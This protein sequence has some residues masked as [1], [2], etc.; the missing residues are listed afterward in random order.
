MVWWRS[1]GQSGD[2]RRARHDRVF[3]RPL[4][5]SRLL[6]TVPADSR[7][8]KGEVEMQNRVS[9]AEF[10]RSAK[11]RQ[12]QFRDT[13]R[14]ISDRGRSP[15]DGMGLR[16][17]HLLARG[18]EIENLFPGIRGEGGAID[19]FSQRKIQ[20][21]KN[22]RGVDDGSVDIPTRNMASSQVAC[23]NFLLP[24][25]SIPGALASALCAIDDDIPAC[26]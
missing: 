25:A 20:W 7:E 17:P 11:E 3:G 16:H 10:E 12:E 2:H 18:Y 23:V 9:R 26:P 21:W 13:S 4:G 8:D 19:F 6:G 14:T 5:K 22:S 1:L 24:L 15:T